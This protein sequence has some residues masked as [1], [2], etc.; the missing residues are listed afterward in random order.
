MAVGS[1]VTF[2]GGD[3][4]GTEVSVA[5][6]GVTVAGAASSTYTIARVQLSDAG[7]YPWWDQC[8]GA[9]TSSVAR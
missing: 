1:T 6:N 3:G 8:G 4:G 5:P 2:S 9:T 7:D